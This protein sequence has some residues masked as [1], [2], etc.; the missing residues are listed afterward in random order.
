MEMDDITKT[1]T[2]DEL[3]EYFCISPRTVYRMI[4]KRE[5]PFIKIRNRVRFRPEDVEN[6]I[7]NARVEAIK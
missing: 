5:L 4:Q 3:A 2:P 6:F 7:E 1:M